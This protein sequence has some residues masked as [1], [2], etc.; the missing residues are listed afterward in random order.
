MKLRKSQALVTAA[1]AVLL[2][3]LLAAP[4]VASAAGRIDTSKSCSI[5]LAYTHGDPPSKIPGVNVHLYRVASVS[6]DGTLSL[7]DAFSK[8][9][10]D[11]STSQ[12]DSEW[13]DTAYALAGFVA[14]E[15]APELGTT[16]S[17]ASG[18]ASF[19]DL[20]CGL[21]LV[22]SDDLTL[23]DG[24][25]YLFQPFLLALP[26]LGEGDAWQYDVTASPKSDKREPTHDIV[27]HRVVKRWSGDSGSSVR[28]TSIEVSILKDGRVVD[29]QVLNADN[30]WSYSWESVDDGS[31]WAVSERNV[32]RGYVSSVASRDDAFLVTNTYT[33]PTPPGTTT[34]PR[35][36]KTGDT[37][38]WPLAGGLALSGT[39]LLAVGL[40]LHR[41]GRGNGDR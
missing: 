11:L 8:A 41:G 38:Q 13:S 12:S 40:A 26:S 24:T 31:T 2:A 7:T 30:D 37:S 21:Y 34:P 17:D 9:A 3:W 22:L 35:L 14:G 27:T 16:K 39:A 25:V 23:G 20:D 5:A 28:P 33:P 6:Q 32:P 19:A 18:N 29:V 1:I 10:V 36:P 4:Q 15:G